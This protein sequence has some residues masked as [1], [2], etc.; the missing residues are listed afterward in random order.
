MIIF[1]FCIS[2]IGLLETIYPILVTVGIAG[3]AMGVTTMAVTTSLAVTAEK[4]NRGIA[5]GGFSTSLY[6]GFAL[7]GIIGGKIIS[8]YGFTTGFATAG[9]V[10]GVGAVIFYIIRYLT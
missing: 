8:S 5:L 6:G 7:S 3:L 1:A 2:I 4:E 9:I 10:C